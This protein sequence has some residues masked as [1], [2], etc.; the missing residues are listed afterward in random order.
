MVTPMFVY[1][2]RHKLNMRF[3]QYKHNINTR[4][5]NKFIGWP[6]GLIFL[7]ISDIGEQ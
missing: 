2:N 5:W 1:D 6:V 7:Y 3:I 4:A